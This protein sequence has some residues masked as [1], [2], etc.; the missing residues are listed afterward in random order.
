MKL[1][2]FKGVSLPSKKL[3][4][5]SASL[6]LLLVV[7][8]SA[9]IIVGSKLVSNST[10]QKLTETKPSLSS[11]PT[12]SPTQVT[13]PTPTK[14]PAPMVVQKPSERAL[15]VAAF[16]MVEVD[17]K[18]KLEIKRINGNEKENDTQAIYELALRM[19][20]DPAQLARNE[21]L[22]EQIKS[23]ENKPQ[24][25]YQPPAIIQQP[26]PVVQ[27]PSYPKHCTSYTLGTF[28]Y[29]DCY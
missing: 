28:V 14:A 8:G 5:I 17:D 15:K 12:V 1:N 10:P 20:K 4:L 27:Q 2:P 16:I 25:N 9:G 11:T 23:L 6:L 7:T 19:D 29:T 3:I 13:T 18:T 22:M 26:A 21:V 24:V